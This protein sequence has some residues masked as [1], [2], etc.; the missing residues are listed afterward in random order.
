MATMDK[1]ISDETLSTFPMKLHPPIKLWL[2]C[3]CY[4]CDTERVF[5]IA[6][7]WQKPS[8]FYSPISKSLSVYVYSK[9]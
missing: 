5:V 3:A 7:S 1:H 4:L 2:L 8:E 9:E 6:F